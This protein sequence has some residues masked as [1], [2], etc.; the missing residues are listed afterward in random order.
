MTIQVETTNGQ[1]VSIPVSPTDTI[2]DIKDKLEQSHGIPAKGLPL[3]FKDAELPDNSTLRDN[4][5]KHGD[6]VK[7]ISGMQIN[8]KDWK[9]KVTPMEVKP[10]DTICSIRE[11]MQRLKEL[12]TD[13][14]I[15]TF[16][17]ISLEDNDKSLS[18]YGIP[19]GAT[20][21]LDRFKIYVECPTH[22]KFVMEAD[23]IWKI[24]RIQ[25]SVEA[26]FKIKPDR[27]ESSFQGQPLA[28]D[29][30][31]G[32]CGIRHKDTVIVKETQVPEFDVEMGDWQN[33][34]HYSPKSP[35]KKKVGVRRKGT[36]DSTSAPNSPAPNSPAPATN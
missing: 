20:I 17:D 25:Q 28:A 13:K 9:N 15:L 12:D 35:Y 29:D 19:N 8:I 32:A 4:A 26:N 31:I 27:Q 10:S 23:P 18:A 16:K 3:T 21:Q 34:F 24:K 22:G 7:V 1:K 14:Q 36:R 30:T 6:T 5:I 33:P 11:H 2:A